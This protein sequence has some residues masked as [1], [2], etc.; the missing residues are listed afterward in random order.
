MLMITTVNAAADVLAVHRQDNDPVVATTH[1]HGQI[2]TVRF[3]YSE[4]TT[5]GKPN[6]YSRYKLCLHLLEESNL[7]A[8]HD[9]HTQMN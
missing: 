6:M 9:K 8:L 1:K 4:D 7:V 2:G 5:K 3:I